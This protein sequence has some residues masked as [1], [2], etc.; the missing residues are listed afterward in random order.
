MPAPDFEALAKKAK[1][2]A[3]EGSEEKN[4]TWSAAD[5][6]AFHD[7][8]EKINPI[9]ECSG[10]MEDEKQMCRIRVPAKDVELLWAMDIYGTVYASK[11]IRPGEKACFDFE[12]PKDAAF[13]TAFQQCRSHGLWKS[14]TYLKCVGPG[15][16]TY[17]WEAML[18]Y[19]KGAAHT[20]PEK[21]AQW[22][23]QFDRNPQIRREIDT[24]QAMK[25]LYLHGHANTVK[26]GE[27][28]VEAMKSYMK[29]KPKIEVLPGNVKLTSKMHFASVIDY[30]PHLVEL[31]L[32]GSKEYQLEGYGHIEGPAKD[33]KNDPTAQTN[34]EKVTWAKM[35]KESM[36][37]AVQKLAEKV[38]A[39]DGYDAIIGFSQ[40]GEVIQNYMNI[41]QEVNEK[42]KLK[43]KLIGLFGTRIYY[44]KYGPLTAKFAPGEL[45]AFVCMGKKDDE[46]AKDATRD[47][48]NFW[49]LGEFT[50]V[51][52]AQGIEVATDT[53]PGGHE[54]PDLKMEG[55]DDIK[56]M[57]TRLFDFFS[58]RGGPKD[59]ITGY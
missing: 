47:T 55:Q 15:E 20:A 44:K 2:V 23:P 17:N 12:L 25:I 50:T 57:Y 58:G 24:R 29:A 37:L 7:L 52:E 54:M 6:Q 53:H 30:S 5:F 56:K 32:S 8:A 35:S 46:D 9:V 27:K 41:L 45:K 16:E 42:V 10:F 43:T 26:I 49:D 1:L 59:K 51:F 22:Y 3:I 48:D 14:Q 38:I 36:D 31:G 18:A 33:P 11:A 39:D 21:A 34:C 13:V 19:E 40:G 28:Q 4:P